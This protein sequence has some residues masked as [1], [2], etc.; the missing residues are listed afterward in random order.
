MVEVNLGLSP[1]FSM[2]LEL[3]HR[4]TCPH[5]SHQNGT[6]E[7][8]HRHVVESGLTLLAHASIPYKYWDH[9]FSTAVYLIN[10]LPT[11]ALS[12]NK[13]PYQ[14][15]FQEQPAYLSLKIFG[16]ACFPHLRPYNQYKMQFRSAECV[17]LGPSS[18]HKGLCC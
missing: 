2:I 3:I 5:T 17:Y 13:S 16:C 1:N 8:K 10:R 14:A 15:L 18:Q 12:A 6:V 11:V 7:R 9:S 4:F